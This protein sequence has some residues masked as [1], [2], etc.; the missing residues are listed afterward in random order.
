MHK[1]IKAVFEEDKVLAKAGE[2]YG[3]TKFQ[4]I[5]DAENYVYEIVKDN[6]PYILKITHTIR[7]TPEYIL[8]EME[9]LHHL[10]KGGLSA[11]KPIPSLNGR[12]VEEVPDGKGGAFLL[13][14]YEKAPGHKVDES[15][16]NGTLFYELGKYTGNMHRLTK[17]YRP[18][19]PKYKRQEWDEEEQLKL[20]KYV[21]ADQHLVF[22]RADA[23][24]EELRKLPKNPESYGL[25]HADLH[26]GNFNWDNGKITAFDFDDIGYNWFVNDISILLYNMLWYP[27][28]PYEDKAA[29]TGEFMTHF[30]KGYREENDLDPAW[31]EKIPDFLRLRHML[32]Y[33]LLH[34][35][36][37][38]DSLGDEELEML[39]GFRRDIENETPITEYHFSAFV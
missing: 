15:D 25:V 37:D 2:I 27:V 29:F 38:L 17:S 6:E 22:E 34:Q 7:R 3:F 35:A 33:G 36:F 14:V 16:W 9:W 13:R 24:M 23:L 4:F 31:L 21:P 5:A 11:A 39:K 1:D 8:G 26:H 20:R 28:I 30:M 12:D 10:T 18:S 32:I 19:D